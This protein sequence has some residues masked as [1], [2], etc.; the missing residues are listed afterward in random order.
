MT[1]KAD[2]NAE[3]WSLLRQAPPLAGLRVVMADR[4]GMVSESLSMA[5]AY[6]EVRDAQWG[7]DGARGLVEELA[8]EGPELDRA[9]FGSLSE[10]ARVDEVQRAA[11][12]TVRDAVALLG[13]KATPEEAEDYR[14]FVLAL[15]QR[16]A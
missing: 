3:E 7:G 1:D 10:D 2:F 8:L 9:R 14:R 15:A 5:R 12:D 13:R 4:G 16:V 11:V 6:T